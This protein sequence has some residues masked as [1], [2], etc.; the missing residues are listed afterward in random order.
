M[1]EKL[2]E[3]KLKERI[4]NVVT[5]EIPG[6]N[7]TKIAQFAEVMAEELTGKDERVV[8]NFLSAAP[9]LFAQNLSEQ[10]VKSAVR[11]V[12]TIYKDD[13]FASLVGKISV[14]IIGR[15]LKSTDEIFVFNF[16]KAGLMLKEKSP[17]GFLAYFSD[18]VVD[19]ILRNHF[20]PSGIIKWTEEIIERTNNGKVI[21]TLIDYLNFNEDVCNDI[22][23]SKFKM[24]KSVVF[25]EEIAKDLESLVRLHYNRGLNPNKS[26]A[27][28]AYTTEG[29][30]LR[31]FLPYYVDSM[32]TVEKNKN[33][34]YIL[35]DH[36]G[37]HIV[38]GSFRA[39]LP[40]FLDYLEN[41]LGKSIVVKKL[42][43]ADSTSMKLKSIVYEYNGKTYFANSLLSFI[44]MFGDEYAPLLKDLWNCIEDGKI[45]AWWLDEKAYGRKASYIEKERVDAEKAGVVLDYS[46]TGIR[47]AILLFVRGY[48][49][50]SD[51]EKFINAVFTGNVD[52][53]SDDEKRIVEIIRSTGPKTLEFL[54]KYSNE[55][56]RVISTREYH[57]TQTVFLT[58]RIVNDLKELVEKGEIGKPDKEGAMGGLIGG[59]GVVELDPENITF[60]I[61]EETQGVPL[62][63][64][65]EDIRKKFEDKLKKFLE[66]LDK[67]SK[68]KLMQRMRKEAGDKKGEV[69]FD[70]DTF[71]LEYDPNLGKTSAN[72]VIPIHLKKAV[73]CECMAD[74]ETVNKL[75]TIFRILA[76]PREEITYGDDGEEIDIDRRYE[77]LLDKKRLKIIRDKDYYISRKITEMREV[78]LEIICDASGSTSAVINGHRV[79][80]Y[81]TEAVHTTIAALS[82]VPKIR[83]GYSFYNSNGPRDGTTIYIGKDIEENRIKYRKVEPGADNRDGAARRAII[84]KLLERKEPVKILLF[85][86]DSLPA[87]NDYNNGPDD[88]RD[89]RIEGEKKGVIQYT[90]TVPVNKEHIPQFESKEKFYEYMYGEHYYEINSVRDL[91]TAFEKFFRSILPKLKTS[92]IIH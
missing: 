59:T 74:A 83:F 79:I 54:K 50:A 69:K 29:D 3:Q 33:C 2:K 55:L 46:I 66:K 91:I 49:G 88:V 60:E 7:K 43:F 23:F 8:N 42:E 65:P 5:R 67:E 68:D 22:D 30:E 25:Y 84:N 21:D 12:D 35:T 92:R 26:I 14:D 17:L 44:T 16:M 75:S 31:I 41:D 63:E 51:R 53:L 85:F 45:D 11:I 52:G 70:R 37:G 13:A 82:V 73:D 89:A 76:T 10:D 78:A 61:G 15:M 36:E 20:S 19:G 64:L 86:C 90:I 18:D 80:D 72:L 56:I 58:F 47:N 77:W 39:Y 38:Y 71:V 62:N 9:S 40:A 87:D 34:Y 57:T 1:T 4:E 24:Q 6:A 48:A 81:L 27:G 32:D 28:G